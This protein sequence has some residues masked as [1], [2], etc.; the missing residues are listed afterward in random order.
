VPV[1][2]GDRSLVTRDEAVRSADLR[3]EGTRRSTPGYHCP[4]TLRGRGGYA[5]IGHGHRP[6]LGHVHQHPAS[7]Y[8]T[9]QTLYVDGGFA[10]T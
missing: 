1:R 5:C 2:P 10:A 7:A 4:G 8:V 3:L 9:G 6:D